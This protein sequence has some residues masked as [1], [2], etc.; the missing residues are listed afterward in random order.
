MAGP[1]G[2]KPAV[3]EAPFFLQMQCLR[4]RPHSEQRAPLAQTPAFLPPRPPSAV[5]HCCDEQ[6]PLGQHPVVQAPVGQPPLAHGA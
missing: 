5:E 2:P 1:V 4:Q 3:F 6:A